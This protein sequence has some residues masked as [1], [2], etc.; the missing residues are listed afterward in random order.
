MEITNMLTYNN[1][2]INNTINLT[3]DEYRQNV[4]ELF[5]QDFN[6]E[7]INN[8]IQLKKD[9]AMEFDIH[10]FRTMY[11][12]KYAKYAKYAKYFELI[13]NINLAYTRY[14]SNKFHKAKKSAIVP[15]WC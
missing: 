3:I 11:P 1:Y 5:Y 8:V 7:V 12:I 14:T 15:Y 9:N 10:S 4:Q 6:L 2:L 13:D